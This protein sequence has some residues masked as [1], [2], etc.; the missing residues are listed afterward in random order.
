MHQQAFEWMAGAVRQLPI[1]RSVLEFGSRNVNGSPRSLF[2]HAENYVGVDIVPGEGVD[3]VANAAE[4]STDVRY[5]TVVCMEVLEHT[6]RGREICMNAYRH[7]LRGGVFLLT[8]AGHGREPHSAVDGKELKEGE[9]YRNITPADLRYWLS[10][11][12]FFLINTDTPGDIY[13]L[14]VKW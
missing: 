8:A 7:L 5:D 2:V 11:F 1:R 6:D 14:C 9:Y 12:P 3:V 10:D 4:Y 13:A